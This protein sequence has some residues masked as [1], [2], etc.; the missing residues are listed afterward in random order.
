MFGNDDKDSGLIQV[1]DYKTEYYKYLR[2][3]FGSCLIATILDKT[4]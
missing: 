4:C 2:Y 1:S 3:F